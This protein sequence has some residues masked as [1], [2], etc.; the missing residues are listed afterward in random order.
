M[1]K[2]F[3][4]NINILYVEDEDEVR[5]LTTL[6]LSK[7]VNNVIV[8][9]NGLEGFEL[10][11]KHNLD[12]N[13]EFK[14][15]L[16]VTDINMPKM[17][18]LEMI[19]E[20]AK[21]DI[22]TPSI[23]TTAHGDTGFLQQAIDSRVRGYVHKPLKMDKLI[24]T[25][26]LA[27]EPKFLKE[28]LE[29]LNKK[30]SIEVAEKTMELRFILDSQENIIFV[31]NEDKLSSANKA[32]FDFFMVTSIEEFNAKNRC[33]SSYFIK[34]DSC[35][36][37]TDNNDWLKDIMKLDDMKRLVRIKNHNNED[38]IFRVNVKSF[39][40]NTK[41]YV[42]SLTDITELQEYT[43]ELQYQANHDSLTKLFNRAKFNSELDKEILR[44]NR[45]QHKLSM[46]MFDIDDFKNI[47]DTYGH[48]VG[49]VVLINIAKI[50][51]NSIRITD[52][53]CRWGG[54]EFMILLP[55]TPIKE[56]LHISETIRKN[57]EEY[58]PDAVELPVTVSIGVAE[59]VINEDDKESFVKNVDIALYEAKRTGKNKVVEYEK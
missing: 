51:K 56:A 17:N 54:E 32:F 28:K 57:I 44:E 6:I 24:D 36:S 38:R 40:Y 21:I 58:Q 52:F 18:G 53:G 59:F 16:V 14:I 7:F 25:I 5:A 31:I 37:P 20:I 19:A 4:K 43:Y 50:L 3:L 34:N 1:D 46:L 27:A 15:D 8:A 26:S 48:D 55:E 10:F 2:S 47:N 39:N 41:H 11:K 33:V 49:D 29:D 23:I 45:Y 9:A 13:S 42:T 12:D 35:F 22:S 30:L